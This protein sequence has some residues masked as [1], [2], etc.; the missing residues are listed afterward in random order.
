MATDGTDGRGGNRIGGEKL[1]N[2]QRWRERI[3][4][5]DAAALK[6]GISADDENRN[7]KIAEWLPMLR[8]R[9]N[10]ILKSCED[11]TMAQE[12][13]P[14]EEDEWAQLNVE[15]ESTASEAEQ[16][17][18]HQDT[19]SPPP[20]IHIA[21]RCQRCLMTTV[22]PASS[23]RIDVSVPLAFLRRSNNLQKKVPMGEDGL[24]LQDKEAI[25]NAKRGP[26]F[27]VYAVV[28]ASKEGMLRVGDVVRCAWRRY[29]S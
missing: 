27:G 4:A 1:F 24:P 9:P 29:G 18:K 15:S 23:E 2:Q 14:W 21:A 11:A 10:I 8:F 3:L 16:Q 28:P 5:E 20:E 26:C 7:E 25:A 6:Q 17:Q 12:L 22:D 19:Q 13:Q